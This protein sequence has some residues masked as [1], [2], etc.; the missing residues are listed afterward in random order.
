MK[1]EWVN[2]NRFNM[3][4]S[5]NPDRFQLRKLWESIEIGNKWQEHSFLRDKVL[6]WRIFA[7]IIVKRCINSNED[8][9]KD[10]SI[11]SSLETKN[12]FMRLA[13]SWHIKQKWSRTNSS[14]ALLSFTR[15]TKL[16][17]RILLKNRFSWKKFNAVATKLW[18][19][20]AWL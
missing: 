20:K 5:F 9:Q 11:K 15:C 8:T 17:S 18:E 4:Q 6:N 12:L 7:H 2:G 16:L 3:S 13:S 1:L 10:M 14:F 19:L